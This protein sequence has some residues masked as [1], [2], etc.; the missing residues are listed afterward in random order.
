MLNGQR[1]WTSKVPLKESRK[2]TFGRNAFIALPVYAMP[3]FVCCHEGFSTGAKGRLI[4]SLSAPSPPSSVCW[5]HGF[6]KRISRPPYIPR[7]TAKYRGPLRRH[8]HPRHQYSLASNEFSS[9]SL[10]LS[11]AEK[12]LEV[13]YGTS[14]YWSSRVLLVGSGISGGARIILPWKLW[15]DGFLKNLRG[16]CV[17]VRG[18]RIFAVSRV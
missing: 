4:H 14:T 17:C 6:N 16:M 1:P 11:L 8:P 18:E 3:S 13:V 9:L 12:R 15:L 10:S 2:V 7:P 5:S